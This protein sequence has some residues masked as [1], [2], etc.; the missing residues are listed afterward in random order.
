V[1]TISRTTV[2]V[3]RTSRAVERLI[4]PGNDAICPHC[5]APVKF[6]ARARGHQVIAN[7]YV[8]ERWNRV[9]QYHLDCYVAAAEP[10]GVASL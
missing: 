7:I 2:P 4:E 8:R 9:E 5:H 6:V 1:S 3:S 10:Y